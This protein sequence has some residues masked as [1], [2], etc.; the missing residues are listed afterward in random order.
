M[1]RPQA[2]PD[3]KTYRRLWVSLFAFWLCFSWLGFFNPT[4]LIAVSLVCGSTGICI[5]L[6]DYI[7][8]RP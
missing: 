4:P 2:H 6:W 8:S 3:W 5:P 1:T 7:W